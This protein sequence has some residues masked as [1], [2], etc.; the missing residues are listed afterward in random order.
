MSA[1]APLWVVRGNL[2]PRAPD[3]ARAS[4]RSSDGD[5]RAGRDRRDRRERRTE[6]SAVSIDRRSEDRRSNLDRR[7]ADRPSPAACAMRAW[8]PRQ[9]ARLGGRIDV[10]V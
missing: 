10:R 1:N 9:A 7:V 3:S 6:P 2:L 4:S 8:R 5:R